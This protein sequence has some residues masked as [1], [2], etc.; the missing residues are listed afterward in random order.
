MG[1]IAV[2]LDARDREWT[3]LL[4]QAV[5][6]EPESSFENKKTTLDAELKRLSR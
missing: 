6:A 5:L 4:N 3:P 2:L 1:Q